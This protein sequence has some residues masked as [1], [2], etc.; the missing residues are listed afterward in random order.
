MATLILTAVGSAIGGPLGG[1]IGGLLGGA[2]DRTVLM[3]PKGR[4][5]PRLTELKVQTSSYGTPIPRLYGAMRVAGTVVWATDL[6]ETRTKS[7]GGKGKPSTTTYS[8]SASF[9]VLLSARTIEGVGRVWADGQLLR[10]SAGD[11]KVS[12]GFRLHSGDEGQAPDPLIAAAE[13]GGLVPALRGQAYAVFEDLQLADYGNRIP[14][15]TFEVMA[16]AAPVAIGAIAADLGVAAEAPGRLLHG[17]SAYGDSVRGVLESLAE[18]DGAWFAETAG[19]P[20]MRAGTGAAVVIGDVGMA[21]AGHGARRARTLAAA[22]GVPDTLAVAHYDPARDYQTGVQRAAR[23]GSGGR[24]LRIDLPAALEAGAARAVAEGMLARA[25]T[26]R[27]R[28]TVALGV[29]DGIALRPGQRVTVAG[30]GG[31]W[32]IAR[33]T[34]ERLVVRLELER[35]A[36]APIAIAGSPGRVSGAP[37]R[38]HGPTILHA[39]ELPPLDDAVLGAPRLTVAAAGGPGWRQAALVLSGDDGVSWT[40][41]GGVGVPATLGTVMLPP[42]AGGALLTDGVATIEVELAHA[43]MDLADADAAA[44]DRGANLA[45]AGDELV[46][47]GRAEPIGPR[48]WRLSRLL[49][50]RRG[51][52]WAAGTQIAGD[53]FVLLEPDALMAIDLPLASLGKTVRLLASGVGDLTGPAAAEAAIDGASLRPPAPVGLQWIASDDGGAVVRWTRRSRAGW[54]WLDGADAPLAE[55]TERYRVEV[56]PRSLVV[57]APATSITAAERAAG[58]VAVTVRQLGTYAESRAVTLIVPTA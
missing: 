52:E 45:L 38:V 13:G 1:A 2:L 47:F 48:R 46:Q 20:E 57:E 7:G 19:G 41:A 44:L 36:R 31:A 21:A 34:L 50:G 49:R 16:D 32:R 12:T 24:E 3:K 8:Y 56:G 37:D 15:L 58:P 27:E 33:W 5:G 11:L 30:E 23:S 25:R 4:Q 43:G 6:K 17:F 9:A 35:I 40:A 53:R 42:A 55:E 26:R 28:R 14:S 10:G 18:I 39:F 29:T 51:T 54:R 22:E